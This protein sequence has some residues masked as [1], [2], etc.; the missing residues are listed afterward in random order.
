MRNDGVG[1]DAERRQLQ[2]DLDA[3][4]AELNQLVYSMSHDLAAPLRSVMGFAALLKER[5]KGE[6]D[7][8]ADEFLDFIAGGAEQMRMML[9][10]VLAV[11]RVVSHAGPHR[12]VPLA[13][14][15][16]ESCTALGDVIERTGARVSVADG[17]PVVRAEPDQLVLLVRHLVDNAARFHRDGEAPV[18]SITASVVGDEVEVA[19]ADRGIGIDPDAAVKVF[20]LFKQLHASTAFG[21]QGIG[22]ALAHKIVQRHGGAIW[23]EPAAGGG[24]VFRFTLPRA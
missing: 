6:L 17:L 4:R 15:V 11:S 19:V 21:G 14:A 9:D 5:Y 3:T 13:D 22:L 10:G 18:I 20:G 23:V 12:P 8:D 24:S 7:A 2:A 1:P 16:A